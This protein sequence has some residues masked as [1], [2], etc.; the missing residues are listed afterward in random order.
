MKYF[1]ILATGIIFVSAFAITKSV[2]AFANTV[3]QSQ[4]KA[5]N[6]DMEQYAK[7]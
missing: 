3:A 6:F 7:K 2:Q 1:I 5:I 4:E